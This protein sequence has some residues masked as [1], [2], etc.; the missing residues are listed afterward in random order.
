MH[1]LDCVHSNPDI[2]SVGCEGHEGPAVRASVPVA[3]RA[4]DSPSRL[5]SPAVIQYY[6]GTETKQSGK[7]V[8]SSEDTLVSVSKQYVVSG[9]SSKQV[10]LQEELLIVQQLVIS[11]VIITANIPTNAINEGIS[12]E[13]L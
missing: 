12:P 7:D 3:G 10:S 1:L 11:L 9:S 5:Q 8:I 13:P 2:S 4:I 6:L